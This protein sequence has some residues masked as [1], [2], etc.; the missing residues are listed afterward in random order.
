MICLFSKIFDIRAVMILTDDDIR[1]K[2]Q[3]I[4]DVIKLLTRRTIAFNSKSYNIFLNI[5]VHLLLSSVCLFFIA[6]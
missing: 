4:G 6:A 2:R 3:L 1:G 5:L